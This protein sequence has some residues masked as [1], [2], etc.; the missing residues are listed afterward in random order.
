MEL[1]LAS[2][3]R[4]SESLLLQPRREVG[5]IGRAHA[6]LLAKL[7]LGEPFV[8][9]RRGR[10]QLR[11]QAAPSG[12]L[13]APRSLKLM[14]HG[15]KHLGIVRQT[16]GQIPPAPWETRCPDHRDHVSVF[17][18]LGN[19]VMNGRSGLGIPWERIADNKSQQKGVTTEG[20]AEFA[21]RAFS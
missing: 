9:A 4:Y 19:S 14:N 5:E 11:L 16:P 1:L 10:I 12:S 13:P 20:I 18:W 17:D 15:L 7:R 8:V 6:E 21:Q 3:R 2:R